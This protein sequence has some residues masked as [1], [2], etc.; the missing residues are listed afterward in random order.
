MP[1]R[2]VPAHYRSEVERQIKQ[3]LDQGVIIESSSP[4]MAPAV[5][6]PKKSGELGTC[7]DYRQLNKHT[8]KDV[9]PLPLPDEVQDRL[10]GC[11]HWTYTV[12]I[13]SFQ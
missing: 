12:N 2:Q 5:F 4:W 13:G 11:I 7:I 10:A 8:L 6:I 3:I 9:Y 1:P